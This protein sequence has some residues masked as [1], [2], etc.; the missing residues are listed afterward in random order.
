MGDTHPKAAE[1]QLALLRRATV[2]RRF[3]LTRALTE[4]TIQLARRGLRDAMPGASEL[5]LSLRFIELHYGAQLAARVA[6]YLAKRP[7]T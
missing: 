6:A 4:W 5:E 1:A 2:A 3:Q 7:A